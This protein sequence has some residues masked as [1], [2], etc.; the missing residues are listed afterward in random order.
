MIVSPGSRCIYDSTP[1]SFYGLPISAIGKPASS[2]NVRPAIAQFET[3]LAT[4]VLI[5]LRK[6]SVTVSFLS[7]KLDC[8]ELI[9]CELIPLLKLSCKWLK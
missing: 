1:V 5:L 6:S 3:T 8:G 4:I 7:L 2:M 9:G